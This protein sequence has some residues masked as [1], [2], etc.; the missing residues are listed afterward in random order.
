MN[1]TMSPEQRITANVKVLMHVRGYDRHKDLGAQLG[2]SE[3][4]MSRALN[5][6]KWPLHEL[7]KVADALRVTASDLLRDPD[8]YLP[9][10]GGSGRGPLAG[11]VTVEKRSSKSER[12]RRGNSR[13]APH[14][15]KLSTQCRNIAG[16]F[17]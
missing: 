10:G 17:G 14:S 4:K 1:K 16:T 13:S 5:D 2:W 8:T 11:S 15:I 9:G 7:D 6:D 3:S 12:F